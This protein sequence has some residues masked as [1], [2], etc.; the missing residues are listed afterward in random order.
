MEMGELPWRDNAAALY[1][2]ELP[3]YGLGRL[4]SDVNFVVTMIGI[5]L[6]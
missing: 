4:A 3:W 2:K 5:L 1:G 6:G